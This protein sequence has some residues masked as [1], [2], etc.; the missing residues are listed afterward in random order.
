MYIRRTY[1]S[2]HARVSYARELLGDID[3]AFSDMRQAVEAGGAVPENSAYTRVLLANLYFN[4]G[5][6]VPAE[7]AYR[8]ALFDQ[9]RDPYALAGLA[10][11]EAARGRDAPPIDRYPE[12]GDA[13]PL[14][15]FLI[16]LRGAFSG[17]PEPP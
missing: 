12:A 16:R 14:P 3:G 11:G 15:P 10:R 8:R 7:A 13:H 6:L 2:T 1:Q 17:A 4:S 9:P 5:R